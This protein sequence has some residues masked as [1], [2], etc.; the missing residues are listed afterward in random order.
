M[1][2]LEDF[3][4]EDVFPKIPYPL[5]INFYASS[6]L[7]LSRLKLYELR[8]YYKLHFMYMMCNLQLLFEVINMKLSISTPINR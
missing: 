4:E 7:S 5:C 2:E 6:S 1:P 3:L 8:I